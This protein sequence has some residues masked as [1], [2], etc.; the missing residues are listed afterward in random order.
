MAEPRAAIAAGQRPFSAVVCEHIN[1]AGRDM[2]DSLRLEKNSAP[3][4]C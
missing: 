3:P 4:G 2:L 1:R